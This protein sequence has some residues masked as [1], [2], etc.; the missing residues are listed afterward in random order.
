M[1]DQKSRFEDLRLMPGQPL[2]LDFDGYKAIRDKSLLIGYRAGQGLIVSTP[3]VNG[4]ALP[5]KVGEHLS[6]RLF[7]QQL[8]C[9]CAFRTHILHV[10]R[11]PYPHLHLAQPDSLTLG[12]VRN[13]VRA[14][15]SLISSL[16]YGDGLASKASCMLRDISLGGCRLQTKGLPIVA[17]ESIRLTTQISISGI[18]RIITLEG[19]VR[20]LQAEDET[21]FAGIQFGEMN[22]SD[23][24]ILH[25]FVL[26]NIHAH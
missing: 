22:D 18:E 26:S 15:V 19:Q 5:L 1:N 3:L 23:R 16:H 11:I 4:T 7:A 9:A 20:S 10:S 12:E 6:V 21:Q 13:S 25:A 24:I 14:R 2:Q 8:N 17:G